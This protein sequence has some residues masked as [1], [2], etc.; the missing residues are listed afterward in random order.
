MRKGV[1]TMR[2]LIVLSVSD[3]DAH[4]GAI[5]GPATRLLHGLV[6]A[7]DALAEPLTFY[8]LSSSIHPIS[9]T[10]SF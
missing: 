3:H 4:E 1:A 7:C 9:P 8:L 10:Q 5:G 6:V 2:P